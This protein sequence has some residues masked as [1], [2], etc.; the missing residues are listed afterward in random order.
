[1]KKIV[2]GARKTGLSTQTVAKAAVKAI[3]HPKPKLRYP[4]GNTARFVPL[5]RLLLPGLYE[6]FVR[7]QFHD[8]LR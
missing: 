6:R 4:V 8:V 7:Q 3:K 5:F 1:M 2:E